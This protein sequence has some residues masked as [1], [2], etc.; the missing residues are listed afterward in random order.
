[1]FRLKFSKYFYILL[2]L[3]TTVL[4]SGVLSAEDL[5]KLPKGAGRCRALKPMFY[6]NMETKRC[7]GFL[8][9]G[10]SGNANKFDNL[11]ECHEACQHHLVP[12]LL[13]VAVN[14][15][16]AVVAVLL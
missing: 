12:V 15:V 7:E 8:Y 14:V 13:V 1:M 11:E 5:C 16:V 4:V 10:C 6:F 3:G 9:K 2:L